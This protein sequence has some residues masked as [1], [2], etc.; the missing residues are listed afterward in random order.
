MEKFYIYEKQELI[1]K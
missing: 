1:T